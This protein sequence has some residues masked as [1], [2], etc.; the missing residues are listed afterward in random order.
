MTIETIITF[1][2]ANKKEKSQ[3]TIATRKKDCK[4][5]SLHS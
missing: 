1:M 3:L 4:I 5:K 2:H